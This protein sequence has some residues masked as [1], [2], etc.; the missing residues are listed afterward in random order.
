MLWAVF[1]LMEK[2]FFDDPSIRFGC[3]WMHVCSYVKTWMGFNMFLSSAG[4][5]PSVSFQ[6]CSSSG[7][8]M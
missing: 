3:K 4:M 6:G 2:Y 5:G 7:W 8:I 1:Y